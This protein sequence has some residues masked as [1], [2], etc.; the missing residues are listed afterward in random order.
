M[1][2]D[3]VERGWHLGQPKLTMLGILW[4]LGV[5]NPEASENRFQA[6]RPAALWLRDRRAQALGLLGRGLV[7]REELGLMQ[8]CI[9]QDAV[10]RL[11]EEMRKLQATV[12][13]LQ[14]RL[15]RLEETVQAK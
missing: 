12:Q 10:S 6:Y 14:K 2:T 9:P 1:V 7:A 8:P 15:D 4:G 11:E 13:E 5:D 3:P